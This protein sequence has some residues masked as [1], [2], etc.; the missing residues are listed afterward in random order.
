MLSPLS[1]LAVTIVS[2][3]TA[4]ALLGSLLPAAI[5]GIGYWIGANALTAGGFVCFALQGKASPILSIELADALITS[6]I[7]MAFAGC[8]RFF[9]RHDRFLAS[10]VGWIGVLLAVAYWTFVSPNF[11]AR[12]SVVSAFLAYV[13]ASIAWITWRARPSGRPSYSYIFATGAAALVCIGHVI[14]S[15]IHGLGLIH[16]TALLQTTP[17][18]LAFL[19]LGI[20]AMPCLSIGMAVLAHYRMTERLER[21]AN[22]DD[23]T[24]VMTRR[25]FLSHADRWL[26]ASARAGSSLS[27]AIIDLDLFKAIN[28]GHGHPGGDQV[29]AHFGSLVSNNIRSKDLVGRLG[30]EEFG[31]LFP[32]TTKEEVVEILD[33]L[34]TTLTKSGCM[35]PTGNLNYTFSA[36]VDEFQHGEPL[37]TLMAR[38]DT[39]L[40]MAK[41]SGRNRVLA[42]A[43]PTPGDKR[44]NQQQLSEAAGNGSTQLKGAG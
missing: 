21:L 9:G 35:L 18:N 17:V 25:F 26:L 37:S 8:R 24:G 16:Q 20:R 10:Y 28:D 2:E 43:Q 42:V 27:L 41:A 4:I 12:A 38:V 6:A 36:G 44:W 33:R 34:R 32:E 15:A 23:L 7:L 11:N 39:A 3:I 40:Y 1:V 14:H 30:G 29:L 13:C 31:V 5:P 22:V 19:S